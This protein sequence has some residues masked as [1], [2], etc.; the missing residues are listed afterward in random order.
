[1]KLIDIT[2][3]RLIPAPRELVFD[4]WMDTKSPGGPW[5]GAERVI[6]NPWWTACSIL[7]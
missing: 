4:V 3:T 1:M 5:Y 7:R 6:L 2:V